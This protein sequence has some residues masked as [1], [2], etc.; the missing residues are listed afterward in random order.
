LLIT[1][2]PRYRKPQPAIF[3]TTLEK[4]FNRTGAIAVMRLL[5]HMHAQ[6]W[7][8]DIPKDVWEYDPVRGVSLGNTPVFLRLLAETGMRKIRSSFRK[9]LIIH[10]DVLDTF[11]LTLEHYLTLRAYWSSGV[12]LTLCHGDGNMGNIF[13]SQSMDSAGFVDFQCVAREHCM[14][15]VSYH[16]INSCS[17][18]ELPALESQLIQYYL[19]ELRAHMISINKHDYVCEIPDYNSAYYHFRLHS[20]WPLLAWVICC[21]FADYVMRDFAINSL[22]RVVDTC[23]RLKSLDALKTMLQ[24]QEQK[25]GY[26]I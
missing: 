8:P 18:D 25:K 4:P 10:A 2:D 22:Q 16:L 17:A 23:H 26:R 21:G 11:Y 15:D 3:R 7:G 13:L 6:Y 14:R 9:E 5:A 12:A 24:E 20:I 19:T 1:E